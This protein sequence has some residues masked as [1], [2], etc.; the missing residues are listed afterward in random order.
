MKHAPEN[1]LP[2]DELRGLIGELVDGLA[3][4][5]SA[6]VSESQRSPERRLLS[7][8]ALA[9]HYGVAP[10]TVKT[11]REKGCPALRV[12]RVLMFEIEEVNRW[13]RQEGATG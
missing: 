5:V 13:L 4:V 10:R 6:R 2:E 11:W 3:R 1:K 12:G 8:S 9:E 7:K